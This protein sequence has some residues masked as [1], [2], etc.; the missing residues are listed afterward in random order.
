MEKQGI[1]GADSLSQLGVWW[2]PPP[3][4]ILIDGFLTKQQRYRPTSVHGV[5]LGHRGM[6]G[7]QERQGDIA[8]ENNSHQI[9]KGWTTMKA[10]REG[11]SDFQWMTCLGDYLDHRVSGH[12]QLKNAT[13]GSQSCQAPLTRDNFFKIS[14]KLLFIIKQIRS[15]VDLLSWLRPC[16]IGSMYAQ[17]RSYTHMQIVEPRATYRRLFAVA[18]LEIKASQS[19]SS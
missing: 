18:E 17:F 13:G 3:V 16:Y 9:R 12:T 8:S 1:I 4:S 15:L 11:A 7:K 2:L 10:E 5:W 19:C 6:E 14:N